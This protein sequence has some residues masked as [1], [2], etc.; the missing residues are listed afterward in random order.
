MSYFWMSFC[1][2]EV[3]GPKQFLGCAI[4]HAPNFLS[5]V[6]EASLIGCNPGCEIQGVEIE[7]DM[8]Q[9]PAEFIGHL[10]QMPE[11]KRFEAEMRSRAH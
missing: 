11:I 9:P 10:M 2:S 4:V 8:P 3:E 7:A 5:A 6:A 1:D